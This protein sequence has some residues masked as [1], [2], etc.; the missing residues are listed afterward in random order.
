MGPRY[1]R[2]IPFASGAGQSESS[3][4]E[5]KPR[6]VFPFLEAGHAVDSGTNDLSSRG[7]AEEI[8]EV[9]FSAHSAPPR[10]N[11]FASASLNNQRSAQTIGH[12]VSLP[13]LL[14]AD[15]FGAQ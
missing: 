4:P 3:S 8:V 14:I 10:E 7:D 11:Q 15:R 12:T 9:S 1:N 2:P 5:S 13:P 6:Q